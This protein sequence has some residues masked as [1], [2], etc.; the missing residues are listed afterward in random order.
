[1]A[2]GVHLVA[3]VA[4]LVAPVFVF[5]VV[6]RRWW[7]MAV[8]EE[9]DAGR[10]GHV[11]SDAVECSECGTANTPGYRFCANCL[12]ELPAISSFGEEPT[13]APSRRV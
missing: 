1:M 12:A 3:V 2:T 11:D 10:P 5:L 4:L 7:A 13:P 9:S 8:D 6:V